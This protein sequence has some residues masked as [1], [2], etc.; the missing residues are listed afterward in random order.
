[1]RRRRLIHLA[2]VGLT[3]GGTGCIGGSNVDEDAPTDE[4]LRQ[5]AQG[6]MGSVMSNE[7]TVQV[8]EEDSNY[9]VTIRYML[10]SGGDRLSVKNALY[11]TSK[12][13]YDSSDASEVAYVEVVAI[14]TLIDQ[15]GNEDEYIVGQGRLPADEGRR[16]NWDGVIIQDVWSLA[17]QKEF[18]NDVL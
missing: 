7:I 11:E 13:V 3:V 6:G 1:M 2:G 14:Q 10:P 12:A 15:Y 4:R 18:P 8:T 9:G 16:I 17:E 5:R